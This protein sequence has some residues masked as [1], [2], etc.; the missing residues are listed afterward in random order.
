MSSEENIFSGGK[1]PLRGF[2][3]ESAKIKSR[4]PSSKMATEEI[5]EVIDVGRVNMDGNCNMTKQA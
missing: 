3:L 5:T 1:K 4:A 2:R